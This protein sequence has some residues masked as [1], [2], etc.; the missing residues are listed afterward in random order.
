MQR[1]LLRIEAC[2]TVVSKVSD[3][4]RFNIEIAHVLSDDGT[5]PNSSLPVVIYRDVFSGDVE[6]AAGFENTFTA[7]G[8]I[9]TWR[10]GIYDYHHYHSTSHEVLGIAR[11]TVTV[12]LG[13]PH[14]RLFE[15]STGDAVVIPAGVSHKNVGS[16]ED[17]LV[18]GAYP[19][20]TSPDMRYVREG[21]R[22]E[23]D[24]NIARVPLP[25]SDPIDG[26]RG[27]LLAAWMTDPS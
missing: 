1:W 18:V 8:W 3:M 26:V 2:H 11:G 24:E 13:G 21:E 7:N 27:R 25:S 20:G 15:L 5:F 14:G 19:D 9:D 16:S 12:H 23:A 10:N 4:S 17:L 22:P 6:L